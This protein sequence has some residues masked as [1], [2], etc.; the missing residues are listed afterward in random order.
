MLCAA[1]YPVVVVGSEKTRSKTMED[2]L[3]KAV[4]NG[5]EARQVLLPDTISPRLD[6][7]RLPVVDLEDP[8]FT[9]HIFRPRA[10]VVHA[11][12]KAASKLLMTPTRDAGRPGRVCER[13][14]AASGGISR[15]SSSRSALEPR[16]LRFLT[17]RVG[18]RWGSGSRTGPRHSLW[19]S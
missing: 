8:E 7:T 11:T 19:R 15:R 5:L 9:K 6:P 17:C 10:D 13:L 4:E 18:I 12:D 3:S 16:S 14:T 1:D 2:A